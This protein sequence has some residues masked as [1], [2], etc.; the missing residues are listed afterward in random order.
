[1]TTNI[2]PALTLDDL[3]TLALEFAIIESKCKEPEL[4][5]I[6]DGKLIIVDRDSVTLIELKDEKYSVH[7]NDTY[8]DVYKKRY[9]ASDLNEI[10][11][12]K[13]SLNRQNNESVAWQQ[14]L[15][16][17]KCTPNGFDIISRLP[18]RLK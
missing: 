2:K 7:S 11:V 4:F 15:L 8:L 18:T 12:E 16:Q 1:M 6:T 3:R 9:A 5:G 17:E 14:K 13:L 10:P